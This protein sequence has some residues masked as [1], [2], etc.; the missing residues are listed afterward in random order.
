[1]STK[2][3]F[4]APIWDWGVSEFELVS[5]P[6][7][8]QP[9]NIPWLI[10]NGFK[11][12]F[13]V[14]T[15]DRDAARVQ[16]LLERALAAAEI[17]KGA[18]NCSIATTPSAGNPDKFEILRI[19][20]VNE[21][22]KAISEGAA[23]MFIGADAFYGNGSIRNMAT[24]CRKPGIVTGGISLRVRRDPFLQ[25]LGRFREAFGNRPVSNAR[26]V[27]M[28]LQTQLDILQECDVDSD[29]NASFQIGTSL[30]RV[31]PDLLTA[32]IHNHSPFMFWPQESDV[33]FLETKCYGGKNMETLDHLW[34]SQLVTQ[35][36][37][38]LFASTDLFFAAELTSD[39]VVH[40]APS[41]PNMLYNELF[42]FAD[43]P[44]T[45]MHE[46]IVL[47]LRSEPFL[48]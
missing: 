2:I 30:R 46:Q 26:L 4:L 13:T 44:H 39:E 31:A 38:R 45:H 6:S 12:E 42:K 14:Y 41:E 29:T 35:R 40:N 37:W 34:P 43:L 17:P 3:R 48:S 24:Y 11:V 25:L 22:W 16:E 27:D 32:I 19:A 10:R 1:M 7:A 36:R 21:C 18:L 9:D 15:L 8:L 5:L 28:S 20:F 33:Y 23:L 47:T